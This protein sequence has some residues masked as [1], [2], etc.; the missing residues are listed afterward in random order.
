MARAAVLA[1]GRL[2]RPLV[3]WEPAHVGALSP[4]HRKLVSVLQ[5]G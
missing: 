4:P 3:K 5:V 1:A 2:P